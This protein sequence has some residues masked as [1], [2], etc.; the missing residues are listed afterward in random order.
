M[1]KRFQK[2]N[3]LWLATIFDNSIRPPPTHVLLHLRPLN[4]SK[5][6][7]NTS[8]HFLASYV[9]ED[10]L[11]QYADTFKSLGQLGPPVHFK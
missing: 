3:S 1:S 5:F 4:Q 10:I 9:M 11:D 7:Q 2:Q 8:F 6:Y